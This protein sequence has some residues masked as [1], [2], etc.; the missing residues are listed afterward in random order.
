MDLRF[1]LAL[2]KRTMSSDITGQLFLHALNDP[3]PHFG[4]D[5]LN[6]LPGYAAEQKRFQQLLRSYVD[7]W[8]DTGVSQDGR[9]DLTERGVFRTEWFARGQLLPSAV[10]KSKALENV[11]TVALEV[12]RQNPQTF[13]SAEGLEITFPAFQPKMEHAPL[14]DLAE[15]VAKRFFVWFLA[16]DLRVKLGKCRACRLYEIKTRKLYKR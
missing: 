9:Q 10:D 5:A 7:Q 8:I 15:R 16:S 1:R 13:L 2:P 11:L 4:M 14:N 3:S 6:S 12:F